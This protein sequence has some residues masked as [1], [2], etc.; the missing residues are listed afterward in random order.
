MPDDIT[1]FAVSMSAEQA[2]AL[3]EL[4]KRATFGRVLPFTK[5]GTDEEECYAMLA[6]IVNVQHALHHAGFSPR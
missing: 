5:N 1:R 2:A 4:C 6:A 3:A